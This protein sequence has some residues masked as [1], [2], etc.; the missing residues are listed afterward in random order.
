MALTQLQ[1]AK[2]KGHRDRRVTV[3]DRPEVG[4]S[5]YRPLV[6]L[7]TLVTSGCM[8]A[9]GGC[10]KPDGITNEYRHKNLLVGITNEY[11]DKNLLVGIT[12]EYRHKNLLVGITWLV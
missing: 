1:H 6:C 4:C 10:K 2:V 3:F 7:Q 8:R 12:N 5:R 11:R 9:Q